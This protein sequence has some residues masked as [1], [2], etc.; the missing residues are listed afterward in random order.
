ME[1]SSTIT[2]LTDNAP[3]LIEKRIALL[4]AIETHGSISKAAKAVP[5]SYKAAWNNLADKTIVKRETGGKGGGGATLTQYGKDLIQTYIAVKEEHAAF[6]QKLASMSDFSKADFN[7]L[8]RFSMK[9][10]ARNQIK[11]ELVHIAH[12]SVSCELFIK[13]KSGYTAISVITKE[14]VSNLGLKL[15]DSVVAIFKSSHVLITTDNALAISARN[16]FSGKISQITIGEINAEVVVDIGKENIAAVITKNAV[17][18]LGLQ[19]GQEVCAVIKSSD[20]MVGV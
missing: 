13:L 6:V 20:I 3:F 4:E 16:K 8:Q 12:G 18:N 11:G 1:L 5:M 19:E 7:T 2:V 15:G 17:H 9:L 10:S 14:A